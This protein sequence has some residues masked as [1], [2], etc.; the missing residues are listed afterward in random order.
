MAKSNI[1]FHFT[2]VCGQFIRCCTSCWDPKSTPKYSQPRY[3]RKFKELYISLFWLYSLGI[4]TY[5]NLLS[6]AE[7]CHS[8]WIM[9]ALCK[10]LCQMTDKSDIVKSTKYFLN[11]AKALNSSLSHLQR[12]AALNSRLKLGVFLLYSKVFWSKCVHDGVPLVKHISSWPPN[13]TLL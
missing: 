6:K 2:V 13:L 3:Y 9:H 7:P 1:L 10:C 4:M 5:L 11:I 8:L 12:D